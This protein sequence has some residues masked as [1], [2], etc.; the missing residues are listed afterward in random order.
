M[1]CPPEVNGVANGNFEFGSDV[2][3]SGWSFWSREGTGTVELAREG[4]KGSRCAKIVNTGERDWY[5]RNAGRKKVK[6]RQTWIATARMKCVD[7]GSATL[8]VYGLSQGKLTQWALA[9]DG[10]WGTTD[11]TEVRAVAEITADVDEIYLRVNG[12]GKA[13]VWIDDITLRPGPPCRRPRKE[14]E[15]LGEGARW[16]AD[17]GSS[18]CPPNGKVLWAG[19]C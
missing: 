7:T 4:T 19:A 10:V 3:S 8:H 9:T 6:P 13:Q 5:I 17:R 12:F 18:P 2:R 1:P 14:G 11:W 16:E 15:R